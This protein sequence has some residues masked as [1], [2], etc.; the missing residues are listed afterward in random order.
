MD[1]FSVAKA[2]SGDLI[3]A[4]LMLREDTG[5]ELVDC[6]DMKEV[7][8]HVSGPLAM[9]LVGDFGL[10]SSPPELMCNGLSPLVVWVRSSLISSHISVI[11]CKKATGTCTLS[12]AAPIFDEGEPHFDTEVHLDT[13]VNLDV[14]ED[15]ERSERASSLSAG[16]SRS[17]SKSAKYLS[18]AWL[19]L[20]TESASCSSL[21]GEFLA[22]SSGLAG[23]RVAE[24]S[25]SDHRIL[26]WSFFS[27]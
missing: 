7:V 22:G 24:A 26:G 15:G 1:A 3:D 20:S 21:E 8:E 4:S 27:H 25:L 18:N 11:I 5:G 23:S 10:P 14:C 12:G 19:L 17:N 9:R 6:E 16:S 13:E 2:S